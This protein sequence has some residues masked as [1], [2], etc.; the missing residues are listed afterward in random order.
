MYEGELITRVMA[1]GD[2]VDPTDADYR[3]RRRRVLQWAQDGWDQAWNAYNFSWKLV[4]PLTPNLIV[5]VGSYEAPLPDDFGNMPPS[6]GIFD[7]PKRLIDVDPQVIADIQQ[8]ELSL[9][10]ASIA[11]A[12]HGWSPTLLKRV[13]Q[14]NA[15]GPMNLYMYYNRKPPQL[16]D[17]PWAGLPTVAAGTAGSR[18]GTYQ[19][20]VTYTTIDGYEH[21]PS[22]IY[23]I[24]LASKQAVVT[25]PDPG[26]LGTHKVKYVNLYGT[27]A[28]GA[29]FYRFAQI[30]ASTI[31]A[32]P[33]LTNDTSDAALVALPPFVEQSPLMQFPEDYHHTVLLSSVMSKAKRSKGDTRDWKQEFTEG[34]TQMIINERPRQSTMQRIPRSAPPGM[35]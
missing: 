34:I 1:F 24:A 20:L 19:F 23:T 8:G 5:P 9:N 10:G 22:D 30:L 28:G 15:K 11:W 2:N 18:N 3:P 25:L 12:I 4:R 17:R 32:A 16:A 29:L 31:P 7:A 14:F 6:G 35:W 26:P 33:T 21:E 13:V 27:V